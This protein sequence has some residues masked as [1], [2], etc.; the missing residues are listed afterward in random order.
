MQ[1]F[2][3]AKINFGSKWWNPTG[4]LREDRT[5]LRAA[6]NRALIAIAIMVASAGVCAWSCWSFIQAAMKP[7]PVA[8]KLSNGW[9]FG[10]VPTTFTISEQD[11]IGIWSQI[12]EA[13]MTRNEKGMMP[14]LEDFCA[15]S[16]PTQ[17]DKYLS[18]YGKPRSVSLSTIE[19]RLLAKTSIAAATKVRARLTV[20]GEKGKTATSEVY[21]S[22]LFQRANGTQKNPTGW[23]LIG[24]IPATREQF[25]SEERE[26]VRREMLK[27]PKK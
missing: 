3:D 15:E 16:I 1:N 14:G 11:E 6:A 4:A 20:V 5:I 25:Y 9:V 23:R 8:G 21:L 18:A 24:V 17:I 7:A 26:D 10:G 22:P 27:I 2:P 13:V 19:T 12:V